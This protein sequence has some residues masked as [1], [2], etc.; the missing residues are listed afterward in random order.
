M[1]SSSP[2]KILGWLPLCI[3]LFT[4]LPPSHLLWGEDKPASPPPS[5]SSPSTD[6]EIE[7]IHSLEIAKINGRA[8]HLEISFPK[9]RPEKPMPAILWIHGGGWKSGSYLQNRARN[10]AKHGYFTAS[11]EYRF[12]DEAIWPAQIEDCKQAV[13]WVRAHASTY[14]IDPDK[15]GVWGSSAGGHLV[16]CLATMDESAGHDQKGVCTEV[17]SRVQAVLDHCGPV[18]FTTGK[19]TYAWAL[20]PLFADSELKDD[21]KLR[22]ASPLFWVRPSLPPFLIVHGDRD[23]TVPCSESQRFKEALDKVGVSAE[24]TIVQGG[25]H[26][27]LKA[28]PGG[29]PPTPSADQLHGAAF[30]FFERVLKNR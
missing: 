27:F 16:C 26:N 19:N 21:E 4:S 25:E 12:S 9:K 30:Q 24:L 11:V 1:L 8:L 5:T 13:R 7:D 17:S 6:P 2:F 14:H 29:T 18:D 20:R 3:V 23:K 15:I 22:K 28:P 10:Y